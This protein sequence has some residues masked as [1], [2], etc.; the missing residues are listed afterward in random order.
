MPAGCHGCAPSRPPSGLLFAIRFRS[1]PSARAQPGSWPATSPRP[2][3]A[4]TRCPWSASAKFVHRLPIGRA[5]TSAVAARASDLV[6]PLLRA[7]IVKLAAM[8]F[9]SYSNGPGRVSS[10]S[11]RSNTSVRS[12]DA[13]TPKFDRCASPHNWTVKP[14][15]GCLVQVGGHDLRRAPIEGERRH[16]HPAV[17]DGHQ[18]RLPCQVLLLEQRDRVRTVGGRC[19]PVVACQRRLRAR[20]LPASSAFNHGRVRDL[21]QA[22]TSGRP[23]RVSYVASMPGSWQWAAPRARERTTRRKGPNALTPA[24][25]FAHDD[26]ARAGT[27]ARP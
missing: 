21:V 27:V 12:G 11:F 9:T 5:P 13:K 23:R 6:K 24:V 26:L 17:P 10:K 2:R 20:G 25:I 3:C 19:P 8:R 15:V 18:I 16:H 22:F 1:V 4:H 7:A 14:A